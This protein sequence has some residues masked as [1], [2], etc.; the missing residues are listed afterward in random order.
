MSPRETPGGRNSSGG[1][2]AP[3]GG[4]AP[5]DR[6]DARARRRPG[7]RQL[8]LAGT[9]GAGAVG[10]GAAAIG[11]DRALGSGGGSSAS[12]ASG[13]SDASAA[14]LHGGATVPFHGEHQAGIATPAQGF[15][16]FIAL[17]LREDVDREGIIRMLRLL[18][19]DAARLTQGR[20][21]LADTEEEMAE[22]PASLTVTVGFGPG[23]LQ[24]AER[25][26]PAWL[27]PLPAFEIDELEDA[28]IDGDL[29][30]Q[31]C[32]DDPL[33]LAHAARML[34]KDARS[35][36]TVRWVQ[37]G[38]RR[39]WG[40][41]RPG[42]TLRN[43]FGQLDGT[44]NPLPTGADGGEA[45]GADAGDAD[46]FAR[47]V[48][49]TEGDFAGGTSMVIR[50]IRMDLDE[51]DRVDRTAREES[52]GTRL[53]DGAPLT[54]GTEGSDPDFE[55]VSENGFAVIAEFSHMRRARGVDEAGSGSGSESGGGETI[56]RRPY[57]YELAPEIGSEELSDSG[58]IFVSFQ[59]DV[60]GQF[61]PIQQRLS[62]LD[63]L[64]QW[65]TPIGSAVFAIPPGCA[66]GEYLGQTVLE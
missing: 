48:W 18:T 28:F 7:R 33:T 11:L 65:T 37:Q 51:W 43:L 53:A 44:A 36:T 23:L 56:F 27:A 49:I 15:A 38:F 60:L 12:D 26:V 31:V 6:A 34:L 9:A 54:G 59:A 39:A 57:N 52:T 21:A 42:T 3:A 45:D 24:R 46:S 63:L 19:D 35:F 58:Q 40:T 22:D 14:L 16:S 61:V 17:D 50:R 5:V 62:D 8:L 32:A 41:Q 29:L 30:L 2:S 10:V 25:E 47:T 55:A 66:E 13:A 64:N 1:R 4:S 20:A